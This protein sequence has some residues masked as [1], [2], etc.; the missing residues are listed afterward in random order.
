MVPEKDKTTWQINPGPEKSATIT[1]SAPFKKG[2]G[3]LKLPT[4]TFKIDD[5]PVLKMHK[6]SL[7]SVKVEDGPGLITYRIQYDKNTAL[8]SPPDKTDLTVPKK[9]MRAISRIAE[10]I[11]PASKSPEKIL[12]AVDDF[13]KNK[14]TYSLKLDIDD[15]G[16]TP[17][18][19][20]LEKSRMGHCEYFAT[21]TVLL[22]RSYGIPARYAS[23]YVAYEFSRLENMIVIRARHA[24]AW[25]LAYVDGRWRNFDTTPPSS[26]SIDEGRASK[27]KLFTDLWSFLM[28]K[29]SKW[30]WSDQKGQ[31]MK[32]AIWLLLP[33]LYIFARRL[34]VKKK[35]KRVKTIQKKAAKTRFRRGADS[36]FYLIE[37][38][39]NEFG[40]ERFEWETLSS[41]I[42][43]IEK[44]SNSPVPYDDLM[45]IM[46]LHYRYRFGSKNLTV[47]EKA[48]VKQKVS[49]VMEKMLRL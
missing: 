17:L 3:M 46:S 38:K 13:F 36:E 40:F 8:D 30:R 14:F 7:G 31:V 11:K 41:W 24:H 23:G 18:S 12:T 21:A 15:G 4:G 49:A 35:I 32:Y 16:D 9:E 39:L 2:R 43:R 6:N 22:L 47:E 29:I 28:F 33:L 25:V 34:Y 5:L 48:M 26:I 37:K 19:N 20:F 10:E 42:K 1:V 44:S 27:L 45:P